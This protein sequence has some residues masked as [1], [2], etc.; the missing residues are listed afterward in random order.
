MKY[1]SLHK[2]LYISS[3]FDLNAY[4]AK[5]SLST[6]FHKVNRIYLHFL[7]YSRL[8]LSAFLTLV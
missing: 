1:T 7:Y 2:I 5:A 3:Y 8:T 4:C 6:L